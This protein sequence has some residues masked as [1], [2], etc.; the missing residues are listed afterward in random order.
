MSRGIIYYLFSCQSFLEVQ[1]VKYSFYEVQILQD[2]H[3]RQVQGAVGLNP[4][5]S[6]LQAIGV[7]L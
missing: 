5:S 4:P 1:L 3:I 2:S 6:K 7:Y